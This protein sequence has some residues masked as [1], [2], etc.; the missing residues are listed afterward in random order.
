MFKDK[1][2]TMEHVQMIPT[3]CAMAN[4]VDDMT[5]EVLPAIKTATNKVVTSLN[6]IFD[7]RVNPKTG[8]EEFYLRATPCAK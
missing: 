7:Y 4:A 1:E 6:N 8:K 2:E 5:E 3:M